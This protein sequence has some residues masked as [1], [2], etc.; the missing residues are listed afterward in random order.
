M[1]LLITGGGTGGHLSVADA[2]SHSAIERGHEV[3]YVGSTT[4]QD[5]K[6]FAAH[7]AF[8]HT[9]FFDTSGVVNKK[10]VAKLQSLW[11]I[12]KASLHVMGLIR[13]YKIDAIFSVGG[14][15]AAP[16]SMGAIV[17]RKPLFIQEQNA[18]VGRLNAL[19]R[20]YAKAFFSAYEKESLVQSY[21]VREVFFRHARVRER[22]KSVIFL[23]GSQGADFI[24]NLVLEVAPELRD[25]GIHIIH[26]CG[27][28]AFDAIQ[29]RYDMLGV[30]VELIGFS[31]DLPSL[32]EKAD[33]AISRAGASTLWELTSCGVPALYI[34]YPYAAGDHQFYNATF[35]L[36]K[37][38]AW[39]ERESE[40]PKE[41]LL[42]ILACDIAPISKK[43]LGLNSAHS[44]TEMIKIA[45][46]HI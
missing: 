15:S 22:I 37:E 23:G 33:L 30:E 32:I 29:E 1:K 31:S 35:L 16:A 43:L 38:L 42:E 8:S 40:R 25:R 6:W 41:R 46:G 34:P 5:R 24:N 11:Q 10:G 3:I 18:K 20:P 27:E 9:H 13:R 21:P 2:L 45:E 12:F 19:L 36:K 39:C 4:G 44:A 26:Q 7:S 14:F 28:R 17:M